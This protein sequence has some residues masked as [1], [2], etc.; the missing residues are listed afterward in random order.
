MKTIKKDAAYWRELV[1][2]AATIEI[3]H[4]TQFS[5]KDLAKKLGQARH[6]Y[7]RLGNFAL[8]RDGEWRYI[9]RNEKVKDYLA[10]AHKTAKE[11]VDAL[12][13]EVAPNEPY[14]N[15]VWGPLIE[16]GA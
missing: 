1:A 2:A 14:A 10:R 15:R 3:G 5:P 4:V 6:F 11:A 16:K 9:S 12:R 13:A 8:C 7:V